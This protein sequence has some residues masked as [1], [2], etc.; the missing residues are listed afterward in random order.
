MVV[1]ICDDD[2]RVTVK[3]KSLLLKHG[4]EEVFCFSSGM[5]LLERI[6]GQYP[7]DLIFVHDIKN[8]LDYLKETAASS[9]GYIDTLNKKL[10]LQYIITGNY[11]I[12]LLL[13]MKQSQLPENIRFSITGQLPTSFPWLQDIDIVSLLGNALDNAIEAISKADDGEIDGEIKIHFDYDGDSLALRISN[14][15]CGSLFN[16]H[17]LPSSSKA[18]PGHGFG[19]A[20]IQKVVDSYNGF[21]TL[22]GDGSHCILRMVLQEDDI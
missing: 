7:F 1:G 21:L 18:E 13:D 8:H 4:V 11:V 22:E 9:S 17:T 5:Q 15:Y 14:H 12:D 20:N 6:K 3:L 2:S 16:I 19:L 10:D